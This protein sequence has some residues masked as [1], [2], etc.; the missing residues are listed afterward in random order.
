MATHGTIAAFSSSQETWTVYVERLQQYFAANK[1]EDADQQRAILLSVCG[2]ATYRLIRNLVSPKKPTEL[3]IMDLITIVQ[4]HHDPKPSMIVQRFRFNGRNRRTG[5]SVAA[6]VAE[7]RQLAEHC[8]Y[9]TTLNDMLRDRLVCGVEDSR[10]QRRLLAEPGL[11][12]DKAFEIA[13]ASESA[14]KNVKDL[15]SNPSSNAYAPAP[16]NK[17]NTSNTQNPC[18]RCGEKHKAADC[19]FKTAECRKCGKKGH[20]A[21]VCRSKSLLKG[22]PRPQQKD[23]IVSR[24][25]HIVKEEEDDYSM[26]KVTA[27]A[28]KPLLV[29]A[30]LDNAKL[31]MEVDTGASVSII[32]EETYNRLW[33]PEDAPP[34]Q[35]SS[36]K[37]RTYSGEQIGVK[38]STT[39]TVNYK[40]QTEQ[41]PLVVANGSGPSLLGRDWLMKICLDWTNLFCVNHACYSL[42]LQGILDTYTTVFS[43]ELGV[44]KGTSATIRV[45]PTAQPRF[46]K[47]R[48]VPYALKAKIEKELDRLIQQG[49]IEPIEFSEWAAPIVPVLKKDGSI[50]ICGDYKV[51][52]NQASQVDSYPLPRIDDLFASLSGGKKFSK[53]DLAHAY[54]QI[55]LDDASKKLVAINTHKGLFQYNR[56]P[57]GVSAAPSIFQ[58][59]ME[60]LLR[61][62]PGVCL[63]LDDI[64]VSG[65]NDQQHLTNLSAVL[66]KLASAGMKLKPDKCFFMLQEVEYLGHKISAKGLEPI[67]E[68]VRAIVEAPAPRNVSQLKSFL[69][70]LNYYAKFLPNLSTCLAPLYSLL[71]KKNH[72]SWGE[73]QRKAFEEAKTLLT[74]SSVLTHYDPSKPLILAC[75]AS[76]YGLGA[77]LSHKVGEDELPIAFASRSL[78][79]AE[80]NYA[81]ID[82]EALAIVFGVRHFH[83]YLFGRHFTI[84]SDHKPLQHLLGERKGIPVMAS[85]RIQRWALTLSA[86]NYT[87]QYVPG[88][89]NANADGFS[90]LPLSEQPRE[91]PMPQELVYLLEGLE[92]S[93]VTVDQIRSWTD[94]D[95]VLSKV[96]RFVQHGWPRAVDS[97]LKPYFSRQL[98]LSIQDNC[99]LWGN[100]IVVTKQGRGKLLALLHEGHPGISKMKGL[101]RSYVWWP[102]IDADLEAQVKQCNQCQI[103]QPFPP[104]VPMHPWE[105][106]E[107]PWERIHLDY[108]GPFLGKMFLVVIDAHSKWME[109]EVVSSATTQTTVEHL[110]TMFARFGLPKVIVTDNGTCFTSS[111]FA[112]FLRR[113]HIRHFKTAPY[114]PSSNGLAERAVQTFKTGMK[115]QL[116]G[117]VQTKLSRFLF[118]YRLSPHTTTGVAPAE[119]LFRQRPRSHMDLIVPSLKDRVVQQQQRQKSQHDRTTRQ[120][121][122]QQDDLVM[123]HGFNKD[124]KDHWLPGT[125]VS[126]SGEHSY[127]IK[128]TDGKIVRRHADH[129]RKRQ[130]DCTPDQDNDIDDIPMPVSQQPPTSGNA[131]IELRRSQ[132]YR[133]PPERFQN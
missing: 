43:S 12:F 69:G 3:K 45:N 29:T 50:R 53:L 26:Y 32:S 47:P 128:L 4:K 46:H 116:T 6:Y 51:T 86:Y 8:E 75:D 84:K 5:E 92:I 115:K 123:V 85:G 118:H 33:S 106:P 104:A 71:Q 121:T 10:I 72:W 28:V 35:E 78:A 129:I 99:L 55:P 39:V 14:E 76:P 59:T 130:G 88:K 63:F 94:Q 95:H 13:M 82:K 103:N 1:I 97:V 100:R 117:T 65:E 96:R 11:T 64:L 80:K 34:L 101:A 22:Q 70:M 52:I 58:R 24:P 23:G 114:H 102:N 109:I 44:L 27:S 107:H 30:S 105:W 108:A 98:E 7:L 25:T 20:I 125:V 113:N 42:S 41:L 79:P 21:R 119:L 112:E 54:Q 73:K 110:R 91:V 66:Q 83:Q 74:S 126:T 111:E 62:L 60:T 120:R 90:R 9:G 16:V 36:V 38:G 56:L 81:Q 77:V 132:R 87:V 31:E 89:D 61:G 40:E 127:E 67:P 131:P 133:R 37:L 17:L 19:R 49:V 122:F 48:A 93:P 18:Y 68:K 15:Q 2:P 124:L 57:F